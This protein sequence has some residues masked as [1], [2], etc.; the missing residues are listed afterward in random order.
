M[1]TSGSGNSYQL[2]EFLEGGQ[3]QQG[4]RI[5]MGPPKN[6]KVNCPPTPMSVSH[7]NGLLVLCGS[8]IFQSY[9]LRNI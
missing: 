4:H 1:E 3:I 6:I 2:L 9:Y 5:A 8:L 7:L